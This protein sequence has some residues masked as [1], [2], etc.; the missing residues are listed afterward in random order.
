MLTKAKCGFWRCTRYIKFNKKETK[1]IASG[2]TYAAIAAGVLAPLNPIVAS[3]VA[4]LFGALGRYADDRV[5]E[6]RC[7]HIGLA[8]RTMPFVYA[9][10]GGYSGGYCR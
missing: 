5:G 10:P 9:W 7:L 2:A 8:Y 6:R 3:V 4:G 1:R